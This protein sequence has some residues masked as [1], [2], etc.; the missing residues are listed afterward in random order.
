MFLTWFCGH[1]EA[2]AYEIILDDTV[3]FKRISLNSINPLKS[4]KKD[5]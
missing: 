2:L 4:I 3:M 5:I 1:L